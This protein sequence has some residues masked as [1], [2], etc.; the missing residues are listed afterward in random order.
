MNYALGGRQKIIDR[1][2]RLGTNVLIVRPKQSRAVGGRSRTGDIVTTLTPADESAIRKAVPSIR[3]ASPTFVRSFVVK[4]GDLNKSGCSVIGVQPEF[5]A[6][7]HWTTMEGD[8]FTTAQE[9]QN[10]RV[11][12]L[13]ATLARELFGDESP[14]G[15]RLFI[16][17]V[18]FHVGGVLAERGQSLDAANEDTQVYVPLSTAI[19]RLSNVDY[20]SSLLLEMDGWDDLDEGAQAVRSTLRKRHRTIGKLPEDF[21]VQNQKLLMDT[22]LA[23]S[24]RLFRYVRWIGACAL[25]LAGLGVLAI[26]WIAVKERTNEI[27]TRRAIGATRSDIFGQILFEA[28]VLSGSGCLVGL[29]VSLELSYRLAHWTS[30]PHVFDLSSAYTAIAI[31]FGLNV[32][33]ST[34]PARAAATLNPIQALRYE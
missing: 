11:A 14:V 20:F 28:V 16:N 34:L 32:L 33:F 13:G 27:G 21:D 12:M 2:E 10:A 25:A 31:S 19:H 26:S 22:Q 18:P 29:V 30:Q 8:L 1:F 7:K 3:R 15:Q 24:S 4:A 9:R 6:I 17:R 5:F 23:V